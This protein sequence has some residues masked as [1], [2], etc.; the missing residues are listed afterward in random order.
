[1]W[2]VYIV[3]SVTSPE[4]EYTGATAN[5]KQRLWYCAFSDKVVAL[6][7][8]KDLK[9]HSGRAFANKRLIKE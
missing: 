8:G 7:L 1:M 3:R 4:Q 9:S 5:L 6:E 2:C